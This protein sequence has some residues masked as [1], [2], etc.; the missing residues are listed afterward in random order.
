MVTIDYGDDDQLLPLQGH[1]KEGEDGD[2]HGEAGGEGVETAFFLIIQLFLFF[3]LFYFSK[4]T[5]CKGRVALTS[6]F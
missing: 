5:I 3:Y 2:A 1:G 4:S 6:S